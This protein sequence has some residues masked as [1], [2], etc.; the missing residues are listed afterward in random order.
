MKNILALNKTEIKTKSLVTLCAILCAAA[1]PQVF[2]YIGVMSGAMENP[3]PGAVFLP[4]HIP[5]FVAAFMAGPAVGLI[6]GALSPLVSYVFTLSVL[7]RLCR[8][9]PCSRL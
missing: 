3:L 7:V 4:M 5:V 8:L 1:L 6:A 2:H 9:C